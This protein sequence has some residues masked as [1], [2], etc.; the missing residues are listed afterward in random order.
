MVFGCET[1]RPGTSGSGVATFV[2]DSGESRGLGRQ[3]NGGGSEGGCERN[4]RM[5]GVKTRVAVTTGKYRGQGVGV[6]GMYS[7]YGTS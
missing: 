3:T 5:I 2:S 1:S 6:S 7:K 4:R